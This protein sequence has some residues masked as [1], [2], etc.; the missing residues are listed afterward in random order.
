MRLLTPLA[1]IFLGLS[2]AVLPWAI[3]AQVA[4]NMLDEWVISIFGPIV[5]FFFWALAAVALRKAMRVLA[6]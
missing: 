1:L 6:A 2:L 3:F 4:E 5:F